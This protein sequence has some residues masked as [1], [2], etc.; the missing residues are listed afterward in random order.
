MQYSKTVIKNSLAETILEQV[1]LMC[2]A[3][4]INKEKQHYYLYVEEELFKKVNNDIPFVS[5]SR[6]YLS[7]YGR[8]YIEDGA[9]ARESIF[10]QEEVRN[11]E[12]IT[13]ELIIICGGVKSSTNVKSDTKV[14]SFYI[15]PEHLLLGLDLSKWNKL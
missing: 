12:V 8:V 14:L 13:K 1:E 6:K 9:I 3:N 5:G 2:I 7:F 11:V 15:A 4:N 10:L